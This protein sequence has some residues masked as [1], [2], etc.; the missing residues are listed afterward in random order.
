MPLSQVSSPVFCKGLK[1]HSTQPF[2][3]R[4]KGGEGN[5]SSGYLVERENLCA[6]FQACDYS[7][8]LEAACADVDILLPKRNDL[9]PGG[10]IGQYQRCHPVEPF[11]LML[12]AIARKDSAMAAIATDF[13]NNFEYAYWNNL[14]VTR[15]ELFASYCEF[16]FDVLLQVNSELGN[17]S[18]VYQNRVCAFLS[19]RLFNFWIFY[20]NLTIKEMD[21]CVTSEIQMPIE[22][23]Q[24]ALNI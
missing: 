15:R 22:A 19:E 5:Y 2:D 14:F 12:D 18:G 1:V 24:V 9:Q 20:K 4:A 17:F 3:N 21:W 16:A 6:M 10:F 8:D 13:F 7:P 11:H 23:H